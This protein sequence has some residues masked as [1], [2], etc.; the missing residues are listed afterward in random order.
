MSRNPDTGKEAAN[1]RKPRQKA[2][3][4]RGSADPAQPAPAVAGSPQGEEASGAA[5]S[6]SQRPLEPTQRPG[7]SAKGGKGGKSSKG[8]RN[9]KGKN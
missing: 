7:G 1:R 5:P 3:K 9:G 6:G 2:N 4:A 8:K